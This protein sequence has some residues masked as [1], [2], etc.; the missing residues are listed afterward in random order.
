MFGFDPDS[1]G[2]ITVRCPDRSITQMTKSQLCSTLI[3]VP[4]CCTG[5]PG[6]GKVEHSTTATRVNGIEDLS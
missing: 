6:R 4:H 5:R 2:L 3:T 1:L